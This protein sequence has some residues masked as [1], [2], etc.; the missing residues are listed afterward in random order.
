MQANDNRR[1]KP[2]FNPTVA[3]TLFPSISILYPEDF[4]DL[5]NTTLEG[6]FAFMLDRAILVDRSAAFRGEWTGPVGRTV[7]TAVHVG[8]VSRWWWEPIRRQMLRYAR[9]SE[10]IIARN[11][12]GL[13]A[14]DPATLKNPIFGG[15]PELIGDFKTLAPI[16]SYQPVV[17]YISR[18]SS[19]RRLTAESHEELVQALEER[20]A[21][22]GWELVIVEAEKLTK[23]EQLNLAGRTTVS[24]APFGWR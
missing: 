8:T 21:R 12:E 18:Q 17:T 6:S 11:L 16:G 23:E 24:A 3:W 10:D 5:T 19:R 22:K 20:A 7:A 1:D 14:I 9:V 13:G 15:G 2:R 4:A